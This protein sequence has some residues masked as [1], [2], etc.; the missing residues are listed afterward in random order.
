MPTGDDDD[1]SVWALALPPDEIGLSAIARGNASLT[2]SL[3]AS[4]P[5]AH[6]GIIATDERLRNLE[7]V[8][9]TTLANHSVPGLIDELALPVRNPD[10]VAT[11]ARGEIDARRRRETTIKWTWERLER[12]LITV[13]GWVVAVII[14]LIAF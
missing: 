5:N 4:P 6:E 3:I 13:G 10:L 9:L 12:L 1:G 7:E 8:V 14:A 11:W 2:A